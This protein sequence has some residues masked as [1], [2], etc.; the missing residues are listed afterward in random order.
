MPQGTVRGLPNRPKKKFFYLRF[1]G[2]SQD[3]TKLGNYVLALA[4]ATRRGKLQLS[5]TMAVRA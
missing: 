2:R 4:V 5:K 3:R 1:I